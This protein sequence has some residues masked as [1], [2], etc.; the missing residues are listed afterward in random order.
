MSAEHHQNISKTFDKDDLNQQ[1]IESVLE[2]SNDSSVRPRN[3]VDSLL[4][5]H[6]LTLLADHIQSPKQDEQSNQL[7]SSL[8]RVIAEKQTK[9]EENECEGAELKQTI[10]QTKTEVAITDNF[11][12]TS[13][14]IITFNPTH[15]SVNGSTVTRLN[16]D[17]WVGCFTS[18]ISN[19]IHRL[20]IKTE[21]IYV[22][23]GVCDAAVHQQYINSATFKSSR[24]AMMYNNDGGIYSAEK[25]LAQ[26]PK[27]RVGQEWS[28]EVDVEK[29]TLHFF[30]DGVQ[31]THHFINIPVPFVFAIDIYNKDIPINIT[32]FGE[33]TRSHVTKTGIGHNVG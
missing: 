4:S 19:G 8:L 7:I 18:F 31:Q 16:V 28:A 15:C 9:L 27:P 14:I 6:T 10:Q 2:R 13:E 11:F 3:Q 22:K 29:R 21:S 20:S 33:E 17:G 1:T 24:A 32:F 12:V 30:I 26:N 23:I 5:V 25:K